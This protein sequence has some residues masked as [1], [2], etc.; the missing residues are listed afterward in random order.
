MAGLTVLIPTLNEASRLPLLLADL[1]HWP[2]PLQVLVVD[3]GSDDATCTAATLAGATV[4]I[5]PARGRGQQL[6]RGMAQARH[7][8]RLVLHAGSRLPHGWSDAVATV[9]RH[10]TSNEHGWYFDLQIDAER[11]MLRLLELGVALRSSLWQRPYGD[12]GL[13]IHRNLA[14]ATGG[15]RPLPLM[16]DLDLVQRITAIGRMKRLGCAITTSARRWRNRGVLHQAWRNARL[17]H[18]WARG[19]APDQLVKRYDS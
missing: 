3:G 7:D 8:W 5:S 15:Y 9:Q 18:D 13:L 17:R 11:P 16:E 14:E 19:E 12:Q 4:L 2:H 10:S 6:A 1:D